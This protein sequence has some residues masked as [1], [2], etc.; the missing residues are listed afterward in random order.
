MAGYSP[1]DNSETFAHYHRIFLE[2]IHKNLKLYWQCTRRAIPLGSK[3]TVDFYSKGDPVGAA[4]VLEICNWENITHRADKPLTANDPEIAKLVRAFGA[5]VAF[6]V[7]F[8]I[9]QEAAKY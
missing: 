1:A 7:E 4:P 3:G 8:L 2:E 6:S 5:E 9:R